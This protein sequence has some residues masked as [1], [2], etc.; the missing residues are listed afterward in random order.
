M[1]KYLDSTGLSQIWTACKDTFAA[2]GHTHSEYLASSQIADS[3]ALFIRAFLRCPFP[4]RQIHYALCT[5]MQ[6]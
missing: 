5:I 1:A 3:Q 6:E 2:S 4:Q